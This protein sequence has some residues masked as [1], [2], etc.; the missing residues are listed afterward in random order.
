MV[1]KA[2]A[3]GENRG[4]SNRVFVGLSSIFVTHV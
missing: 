1:Y 2:P 4:A 3:I